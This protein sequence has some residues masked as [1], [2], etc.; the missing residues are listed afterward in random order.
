MRRLLITGASGFVGGNLAQIASRL[1]DVT[2][3][4]RTHRP[5]MDGI[6]WTQVDLADGAATAR[7]VDAARPDAVIHL[8]A[9]SSIDEC[10]REQ[11]AAYRANV[12]ATVNLADACRVCGA[13]L[14]AISTDNVFDG[15]RGGYSEDDPPN[16]INYYGRSKVEAE[17]EALRRAPGALVVRIPLMLGFPVTEA[18]SFLQGTV[19]LLRA[20]KP[21]TF[22]TDEWR[23]P[24]DV[25][26]LADALLE[27][28]GSDVS[29]IVHVG[30]TERVSRADIG[31]A[32][33]RRLGVPQDAARYVTAAEAMRGRAPRPPDVSF[34]VSRARR[35]LKTP[36]LDLA[37]SMDR[38]WQSPVPA[39]R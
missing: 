26:T 7:A 28:A 24:C 30:G 15:R 31:T 22:F 19:N 35:L 4:Y 12:V 32:L 6:A 25:F 38:I 17:E 13:R 9:M 39:I 5:A 8:A 3:I 37:R 29:G 10:E 36:L 16:P 2:G 18:S 27:L 1:W 23:T 21:V 20:G 33:L 34:D 11:E 14:V